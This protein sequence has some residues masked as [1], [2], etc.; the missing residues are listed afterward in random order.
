MTT[1]R[2]TQSEALGG[3]RAVPWRL[4]PWRPRPLWTV[5]VI[6]SVCGCG[7][8]CWMW[9]RSSTFVQVRS[10][11]ITGLAGPD[12]AQIRSA[13]TGAAL[14]MTT[15]DLSVAK[16][17]AGVARFRFVQSLAVSS[18]SA[19]AIVIHVAEQVP[20]AVAA[21]PGGTRVVAADGQLIAGGARGVRLPKL[22]LAQSP[23]EPVVSAA[24]ARAAVAVLAAAPYAL[25]P[26][27]ANATW[28]AQHGVVVQLRKGP[29]L[30]FG[31]AVELGRKWR[32]AIAV[33]QNRYSAGASYIVVT[34]PVHPAAGVGVSASRAAALGLAT[35]AGGG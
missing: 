31:P 33:L 29:Q 13:L 25:I 27:I 9:F 6:A 17:E 18:I 24:G 8:L 21:Y 14:Q 12:I 2:R 3:R 1:D 19:H 23:S 15:L 35:G 26:H 22:P 11:K 16:L 32:S 30:Y 10:V 7:W 34:D 28:T 5:L 4:G 20:V